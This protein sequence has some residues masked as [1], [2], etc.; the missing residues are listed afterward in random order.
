[1]KRRFSLVSISVAV[2]FSII[3]LPGTLYP[4][5]PFFQS[6][7]FVS[8]RPEDAA[9]YLD[10]NLGVLQPGYSRS[11]LF[12]AWRVLANR[13]LTQVEKEA[14]QEG[15]SSPT[16][17]KTGEWMK[18][19]T[20]VPGFD[21]RMGYFSAQR[22]L[23]DYQFFL[24]CNDDAFVTAA[25][26]L[27]DRIWRYGAASAEVKEWLTAQDMVF[28]NCSAGPAIPEPLPS[29][30]PQARRADRAYQIA[31]ANFYATNYD[32]AAE[33]FT[34]FA[35]DKASPW[36]EYGL[37]LAARANIRKA[38]IG[39]LL[40]PEQVVPANAPAPLE[41]A[42]QLLEQVVA[43]PSLKRLH[44]SARGLLSFVALRLH[45]QQQ[46]ALLETKLARPSNDPDLDQQIVD[47]FHLIDKKTPAQNNEMAA[48]ILAVRSS[49]SEAAVRH[50]K[51]QPQSLPWLIAALMT[52]PAK[53]PDAPALIAAALKVPA[54]SSAFSTA[55][56]YSAKLRYDSDQLTSLRQQIDAFLAAKPKNLPRSAANSFAILRGQA[57]ANLYDFAKFAVLPPA[58]ITWDNGGPDEPCTPD[59]HCPQLMI[60]Q[61][62]AEMLNHM[63]L[64][65]LLETA[66]NKDASFILRR[67]AALVAW[68]RAVL[69]DDFASADNAAHVIAELS[70]TDAR[71]LDGY[72]RAQDKD[73]KRFAAAVVMLQWPGLQPRFDSST[74]RDDPMRKI[75]SYRQNWWCKE[76]PTAQHA[77]DEFLDRPKEPSRYPRFLS[78]AER[79]NAV[80]ELAKLRQTGTA[81]NYLGSV[82]IAWAKA[83]REDPLAPEALY[84]VVR[85]TRYG[86]TDEDT[87]KYSKDAFDLL[88][89]NYPSSEWTKKTPYYFK[90]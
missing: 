51:Q 68:E 26:A 75:N 4:C 40:T 47:Y 23:K 7:I 27:K 13:P 43:D 58:S 87:G 64:A 45:P 41:R 71:D 10:G 9:A 42:Q 56:Y 32:L 59:K 57:A 30:A 88:H 49:D 55:Q 73:S 17:Q 48:W 66:H 50:W 15:P 82:V 20:L 18:T 2:I 6:P 74:L 70:S 35:K 81:P 36:H 85:S 69:I 19:R 37:F 89:R 90:D 60:D 83:H 44:D 67:G 79:A 62:A 12:A 84:L 11:D 14:L 24:N 16:D 8:Q 33:Q 52:A 39:P 3:F 53:S 31:A 77:G 86:C 29:S 28:E 63:P 21:Q 34:A 65:M 76:R 46:L 54:S 22:E 78:P 5:G 72:L 38:T 61:S 80:N 1:M 25:Y